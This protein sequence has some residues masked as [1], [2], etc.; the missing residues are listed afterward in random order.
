MNR[1]SWDEYFL[2]IAEQISHR[3][4]CD[5]A[6]VGALIVKDHRILS[7][8]YNGS[9]PHTPHCSEAGHIMVDGHCMRVVHAESNA[10]AA[11]AKFGISVDGATI[12]IWGS[13]DNGIYAC[14]NCTLLMKAAGIYGV[15]DKFHNLTILCTDEVVKLP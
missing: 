9:P 6:S 10:I 14:A 11:A 3:A 12:Y 1:P 8:G 7:T 2:S 4:T 13:K 15:I 5:R